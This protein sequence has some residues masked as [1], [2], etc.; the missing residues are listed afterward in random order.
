VHPFL[1]T[2]RVKSKGRDF[3]F[4]IGTKL[5]PISIRDQIIRGYLMA[6]LAI[7]ED[8]I[9][10][11]KPLLVVGAGVA[12]AT[13][14][15]VAVQRKVPTTLLELAEEPFNRQLP[16]ETRIVS[17]TI[18][19][20]PADHWS[21]SRFPLQG[22]ALPFGWTDGPASK[23]A[24]A[25]KAKLLRFAGDPT[26]PPRGLTFEPGVTLDN[27]ANLT[28]IDIDEQGGLVEVN[29]IHADRTPAHRSLDGRRFAAVVSCIGIGME[30][31][32]AGSHGYRGTE[33][34]DSDM[35]GTSDY[36]LPGVAKPAI[37]ISGGGDGALQDFLRVL[38]RYSSAKDVYNKI[39]VAIRNILERRVLI[40]EEPALRAYLWNITQYDCRSQYLLHKKYKDAV[41]DII[42]DEGN[43]N[44]LQP[45]MDDVLL[46]GL[47]DNITFRLSHPCAHFSNSYPL[48]RALVLLISAYVKKRHN[49]DLL[50]SF[51]EI[52]DVE[53]VDGHDCSADRKACLKQQ[54][55]VTFGLA[56][57]ENVYNPKMRGGGGAYP[58]RTPFDII[59]SRHGIESAKSLFGAAPEANNRHIL[60]YYIDIDWYE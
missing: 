59:I 1:L 3:L 58:Y 24:T 60:P 19:D 53:A 30:R 28:E 18:Y 21:Q 4:D 51:R 45:V 2:H 52:V 40:A 49:L 20:W 15:M 48:N 6:D 54:H 38:T 23:I 46:R 44:Q 50:R 36:G 17:P 55:R 56:R 7:R 33:F 27:P 12:G 31:T 22:V 5:Y 16:S 43:Y 35:L 10:P 47:P 41:K 14:A 13:T 57:C 34:W 29:F 9:S 8:I 37:L 26:N 11:T 39:P 25:W 42:N 32:S